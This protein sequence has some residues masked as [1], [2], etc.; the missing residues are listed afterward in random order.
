MKP[1]KTNKMINTELEKYMGSDPSTE[2][3]KIREY[4]DIYFIDHKKFTFVYYTK[5][6][7]DKDFDWLKKIWI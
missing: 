5:E 3:W 7:R 4:K 6:E 2:D 1:K